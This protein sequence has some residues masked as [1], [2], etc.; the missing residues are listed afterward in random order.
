M[1]Q[2]QRAKGR[3]ARRNGGGEVTRRTPD[4]MTVWNNVTESAMR[5]FVAMWSGAAQESLRLATELQRAQVDAARDLGRIFTQSAERL[6][7]AA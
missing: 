6:R 7:R 2:G 5:D 1:P 3:R 4:S